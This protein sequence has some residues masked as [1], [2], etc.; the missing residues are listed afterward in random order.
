[1]YIGNEFTSGGLQFESKEGQFMGATIVSS[2]DHVV[3][4]KLHENTCIY[5]AAKI[6]IEEEKKGRKSGR[7]TPHTNSTNK[8]K[9]IGHSGA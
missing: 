9:R 8:H 3:V 5:I 2:G 1:M 7:N 6:V 4:N